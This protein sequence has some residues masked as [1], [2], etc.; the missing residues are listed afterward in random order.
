MESEKSR[1]VPTRDT[2]SPKPSNAQKLKDRKRR[3]L[4]RSAPNTGKASR[5][6]D[7][8]T[9]TTKRAKTNTRRRAK[10]T[11]DHREHHSKRSIRWLSALTVIVGC[12]VWWSAVPSASAQR[13]EPPV[14][15]AS[16]SVSTMQP[17]VIL[18]SVRERP[19]R[20]VPA[21]HRAPT[22]ADAWE[23]SRGNTGQNREAHHPSN[24]RSKPPNTALTQPHL[25]LI[26]SSRD[27]RPRRLRIRSGQ[28]SS[29]AR[30]LSRKVLGQPPSEARLDL[31]HGRPYLGAR[32]VIPF[33]N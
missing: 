31:T 8:K 3:R 23:N 22:D 29:H 11:S 1:P 6:I 7:R 10:G 25:P 21:L 17:E 2:S 24:A 9:T 19:D 15:V 14:F 13:S 26:A 27:P 18:K 33:G 28:L 16:L 5:Q 12:V 20:P 32:V 4:S 30:E